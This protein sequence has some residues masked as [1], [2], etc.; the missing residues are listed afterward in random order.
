MKSLQGS[1]HGFVLHSCCVTAMNSWLEGTLHPKVKES[2]Y[3]NCV[4]IQIW[5]QTVSFILSFSQMNSFFS[6]IWAAVAFLFFESCEH[7]FCCFKFI[8]IVVGTHL[9][10]LLGQNPFIWQHVRNKCCR[11]TADGAPPSPLMHSPPSPVT[12]TCG[13]L[14]EVQQREVASVHL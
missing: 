9:D 4:K 12:T 11:Q 14:E 5:R 8:F 7:S 13:W 10:H 6:W 3:R 1:K 2:F